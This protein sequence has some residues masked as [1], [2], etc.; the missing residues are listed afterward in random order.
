MF[1]PANF[2]LDAAQWVPK[3]FAEQAFG[4]V[5]CHAA[6]AGLLA[7]DVPLTLIAEGAPENWALEF[8]LA[9]PNPQG[10]VIAQGAPLLVTLQGPNGYVS[11][12][13]YGTGEGVPTWNYLAV[14]FHGVAQ[15]V[16]LD[17][18]KDHLLKRLIAQHE[19]AYAQQ[20]RDM[21]ETYKTRM[22]SG[23]RAFRMPI[24]KLEAKAKLSQNRP[25]EIREKVFT[26]HQAGN[27]A[28]QK[29]AQWMLDLGILKEN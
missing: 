7:S 1:L 23:I 10:A 15:E 29:M 2:R 6:E 11:P 20:W 26:A 14:H 21:S 22:L 3:L 19:P 12:N 28:Q 18:S 24:A 25:V 17:V 4:T 9:K 27:A 8:H 16:T 5:V 13:W